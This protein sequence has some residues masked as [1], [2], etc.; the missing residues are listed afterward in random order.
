MGRWNKTCH[1]FKKVREMID[2]NIET[3]SHCMKIMYAIENC[4]DEL[5][6]DD[7]AEWVFYDDFRDLKS[8]IHDEVELMDEDDYESC[9]SIVN[10]YLDELY[11]L[12]DGA[13]V[14][15]SI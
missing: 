8:E 6:P 4:C 7:E 9:E 2:Q 13:R 5:T 1:S 15:L 3:T 12:C 11:D 10:Y 14:W